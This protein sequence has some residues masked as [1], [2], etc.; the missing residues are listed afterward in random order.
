MPNEPKPREQLLSELREAMG[1]LRDHPKNTKYVEDMLR[2]AIAVIKADQ[3]RISVL[4][5]TLVLLTEKGLITTSGIS[6]VI[7]EATITVSTR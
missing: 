2:A 7:N 5:T 1:R 6:E 3:H 4:E